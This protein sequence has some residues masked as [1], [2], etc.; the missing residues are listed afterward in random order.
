MR[1]CQNGSWNICRKNRLKFFEVE[2][3]KLKIITSGGKF[4]VKC[5]KIN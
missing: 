3:I 2:R 5:N 4:V 1:F